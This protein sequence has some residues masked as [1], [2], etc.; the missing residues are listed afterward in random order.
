MNWMKS[1]R[2]NFSSA[3]HEHRC[4]CARCNYLG[5]CQYIHVGVPV[6]ESI[7]L[8][9]SGD[10]AQFESRLIPLRGGG[11][12]IQYYARLISHKQLFPIIYTHTLCCVCV[13]FGNCTLPWLEPRASRLYGLLLLH[14]RKLVPVSVPRRPL[15][16]TSWVFTKSPQAG[17]TSRCP[18]PQVEW[19]NLS[20]CFVFAGEKRGVHGE[21][22][23]ISP[24]I[25]SSAQHSRE[26]C[27]WET[28]GSTQQHRSCYL[29]K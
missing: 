5:V 19:P 29:G 3:H 26:W 10:S 16:Q 20:N 24:E 1:S 25:C 13:C 9:D 15:E 22:G 11:I 4:E 27:S 6:F 21:S 23:A 28:A 18:L 2:A 12:W 17:R 14:L 7:I 8:L